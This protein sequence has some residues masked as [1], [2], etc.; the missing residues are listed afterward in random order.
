MAR[1]VVNEPTR[2]SS[3]SDP[4][5]NNRLNRF[6]V[7]VGVKLLRRFR[8]S[9][10]LVLFL[11][12]Q[13]CVKISDYTDLSEAASMEFIRKHTSIPVPKVY[14]AFQRRGKT[15]IVMETIS[16]APA[17]ASWEQL[18]EE[19]KSKLLDQLRGMINEMRRIPAPS[20]MISNI[21]GGSLYDCRVHASLERFGPFENTRNFHGFLRNWKEKGPPQYPD[22]DDMIGLQS[23]EWGP[24]VFTHGDLS[25]L[26]ILIRG[27]KIVGLIDWETAGWYPPYWEY[28]SASYV[29]PRNPF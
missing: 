28:T 10:G 25:S 27:D 13:L 23:R 19:S 12:P 24:L 3:C 21:D 8:T 20:S 26:N 1:T 11:T 22:V 2:S 29:N 18:T 16:G 14:C 15:Y 6:L 5:N 9:W 4:I 17:V 7:L